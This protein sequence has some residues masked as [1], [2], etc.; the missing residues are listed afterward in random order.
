MSAA[1]P[2]RWAMGILWVLFEGGLPPSARCRNVA[3]RS[4][5]PSSIAGCGSCRLRSS[6]KNRTRATWRPSRAFVSMRGWCHWAPSPRAGPRPCR[7]RHER[8]SR[9]M[10]SECTACSKSGWSICQEI[11]WISE[12]KRRAGSA[13]THRDLGC[14]RAGGARPARFP[15]KPRRHAQLRPPFPSS[16][17]TPV[18]GPSNHASRPRMGSQ[19]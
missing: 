17:D 16:L 15:R 6:S 4:R 9:N 10:P 12:P 13:Q 14:I 8:T 18:P 5:L 2:T 7:N 3:R 19:R 1:P 11:L